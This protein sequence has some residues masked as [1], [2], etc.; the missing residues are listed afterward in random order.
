M[1]LFFYSAL[2]IF[3]AVVLPGVPHP[4]TLCQAKQFL[5]AG[6]EITGVHMGQVRAVTEQ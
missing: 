5:R 6:G 1:A 2:G 4:Q 3:H